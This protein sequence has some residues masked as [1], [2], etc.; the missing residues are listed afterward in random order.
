MSANNSFSYERLFARNAAEPAPLGMPRRGRYDFAV[1]YPDPE[2]L[3]L[4]ELVEGLRQALAEE[5]R[6]LAIYHHRQGYPPLREYVANKLA[7]DRD[8]HV[9]PDDIILGDGSSQPIHMIVETLVD[10]GDVLLTEEFVY[11]GTLNTMRRFRADIRGVPCDEQGMLP[12]ALEAAIRQAQAE[13][14]RVKFIYTVPTFQNP[15]GW[16]MSLERRQAMVELAQRYDVPILEDDCY[17]DLRYEGSDVPSLYALDGTGRVMYVASFSKIIAPGMRLGYMTAPRELLQRALAAKSG[18][19]VNTFAAFA[20][21]R[22]ATGQL[23]A[24][25]E[26]INDVQ[27]RKRDTMLAALEEH[28]GDGATWSRPQ[29]GLYIWVRLPK[30][31]DLVRIRDRVLETED[32]G[33]VPGTAFAADGVSGRN[34]MR[35]CFG[36]NTPEEIQEGIARLAAACRRE[37]MLAD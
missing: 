3:P 1:A 6:D 25:I 33:Y 5:G 18:G 20:V 28:F 16:T 29:G 37:G 36:Y 2:T 30:Q 12:D 19:S 35:L 10:P 14:K 23:H 9:S 24:H 34:C 31:A 22:F 13:D 26:V 4:D 15:Q 21:H 32:V 11:S 7:R 17:V 8:I 27:R